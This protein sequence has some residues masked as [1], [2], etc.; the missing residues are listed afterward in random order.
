MT[1]IAV[2]D[3][4][5]CNPAKCNYICRS[6]CPINRAEE[7]ECIVID[8][9]DKK[10]KVVEELC[11]DKCSICIKKC[12]FGALSIVNLPSELDEGPIHRYSEN[13]F[14]LYNLPVPIFGKV[15][16]VI[17]RNGIGKSTAV[18]ILAGLIKPNLGKFD[19]EVN[20]KEIV[21]YFK[22]TEAQSYF[23]KLLNK[24][25]KVSYKPQQVDLIPKQFNGKV[26][27]LLKKAD[28]KN[29]L[30]E[31]V[32]TL[33]LKKILDRD[34]KNV[35]GGEL[36]RIAIAIT[37]LRDA[38]VYFFDEP[39][40]YLDI[41]QRLKISKFIRSLA[42][43]KTAV[44][45]IE[46][47]LIILDYMADLIHLMFGK[48]AIYGITSHVKTTKVGINTYLSGYSKDENM[49]F[50][51]KPIN[52]IKPQTN[53]S[54][55][56]QLLTQWAGFEK[57][58]GSFK[59]K[60]ESGK[61]HN[62]EVIGVLGENGIGKTSFVKTLANIDNNDEKIPVKISYKTQYLKAEDDLVINLLQDAI[63]KYN[64]Q[65]IKPLGLEKLF[66]RNLQELSGGELQR[67]AIAHCLSKDA[68][69][70]LLDEPSAYLDVEQRILVSKVINEI[71]YLKNKAAIVV[72][73]DLLFIDYLSDK[74][75]IFEGVPAEHGVAN[76]PQT[77]VSGMTNF[78]KD[79]QISFRR[80]E[81]NNRPRA[82]KV[83]SQ[84]DKQQK[85]DG[86]LYYG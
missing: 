59:L 12:P 71:V 44:I 79:L 29:K 64:N 1:R 54:M 33:D 62:D 22:G 43:D 52:F 25:I 67:V 45:V 16:G 61:I 47:D 40:S 83:D 3:K 68:D 82:N 14:V 24:E 38:N 10:V 2:I 20:N 85:A 15:V 11:I 78:L 51:S 70:Y 53:E 37:V 19:R 86:K 34:I 21:D 60:A 32:D 69:I 80:D 84:L 4:S 5:K 18:K 23:Q 27:D 39:T 42:N 13:G 31:I 58:F 57:A 7:S 46:H 36:Q 8:D 49:R 56:G 26:I 77:L 72:D 35:S 9:A 66:T 30:N 17:G 63:Q 55:T 6:V 76:T 81:D 28:E 41:K 48:E 65:L 73:H 50:R 75:I 74:L